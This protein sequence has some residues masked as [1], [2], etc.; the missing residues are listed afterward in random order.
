[1]LNDAVGTARLPRGLRRC[2]FLLLIAGT[3]AWAQDQAAQAPQ[4]RQPDQPASVP[5]TR[6]EVI[7]GERADKVAQLWPERQNAMVD[8]ANG[9][10]ERGLNEGLESGKGSNG[11]QMTLGGMR[12]A[13]G[14]S[15]GVGYRRSDLFHEQLGVR[16][17]ARGTPSGAYMLDADVDFQG[18]R[19]DRTFLRWYTKY[20]HSPHLDYFG[21]GNNSSEAN[22]TTYR[23][24]DFSSDF[25][26]SFELVRRFHVGGTGGYFQAHTAPS[27]ED[28]VIPIDEAF[29]PA[30][31]P[32][33]AEDTKY[34]RIGVFAYY[35]SR[36]SHT[37]P[38]SGGLLV[39]RYREY[40]DIDLKQFAFR[41]TEF[42]VQKYV[43]YFNRSR[44]LA[45]GG[46]VVL[47]FPKEANAVPMYL[48]P[49]LGGSDSLRGFVPYRFKDYHSLNLIAEHRWHAFSMLDMA[50]F[51]DA[52]KVVPLKRDVA[53]VSGLH[54]SGGIGFRVRMRS[55]IV[56][57]IDF[58]AS[59][60]GV[61][62]S[63]TFSDILD[64]KF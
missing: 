31:L 35:D 33:F 2:L 62:M 4:T 8:I 51:V 30:S 15:V 29:P 12:E 48:Q 14:M 55:A 60:E 64:P 19:S 57:R 63:W 40:W 18:I 50:L 20:E 41:Q 24:D 49:T 53:D 43:P 61:R 58:A 52:A 44:V 23:Y 59:S 42:E 9:L 6:E 1:M 26:A 28:D 27:G 17:T 36:D 3:P 22:R 32:G 10:A 11:I 46:S 39:A 34:T 5:Q 54:Y 37:G 7:A 38:R 47:S 45:V 25:N 56:S 13:Q 16:G 21:E